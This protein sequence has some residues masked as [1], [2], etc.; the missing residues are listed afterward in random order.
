MLLSNSMRISRPRTPQTH[1]AAMIIHEHIPEIFSPHYTDA[2]AQPHYTT[3][4]NPNP[5]GLFMEEQGVPFP[6][7]L[8]SRMDVQDAPPATRLR[9]EYNVE[10]GWQPDG[11]GGHRYQEYGRVEDVSNS[12]CRLKNSKSDSEAPPMAPEDYDGPFTI[13]SPLPPTTTPPPAPTFRGRRF[14]IPDLDY[15]G[16]LVSAPDQNWRTMPYP[17][18]SSLEPSRV[19]SPTVDQPPTS[20]TPPLRNINTTLP[21]PHLHHPLFY[22]SRNPRHVGTLPVDRPPTPLGNIPASQ[23]MNRHSFEVHSPVRERPTRPLPLS[24]LHV[25]RQLDDHHELTVLQSNRRL[26]KTAAGSVDTISWVCTCF[27]VVKY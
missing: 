12:N 26:I 25:N 19:S 6:T 17:K 13:T 3:Y 20:N 7:S 9:V 2:A 4:Y 21:N 11:F 15:M 24:P 23:N 5:L 10:G 14:E 8:P 27:L 16:N 22:S 18:P 1:D